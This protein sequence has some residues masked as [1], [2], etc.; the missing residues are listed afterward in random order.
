MASTESRL[1]E[2][3]LDFV[4]KLKFEIERNFRTLKSRN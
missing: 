1:I 3:D 4:E 2:I